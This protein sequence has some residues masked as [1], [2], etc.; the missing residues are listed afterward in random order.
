MLSMSTTDWVDKVPFM[1]DRI[2]FKTIVRKLPF[3]STPFISQDGCSW[4]DVF[5]D[6]V[7]KGFP[8]AVPDEPQNGSSGGPIYLQ[9]AED[10]LAF[11]S[12]SV[13]TSATMVLQSKQ[14]K[15]Q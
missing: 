1:A 3:V 4:S 13:A 6:L 11:P 15:E 5:F 12:P 14:K 9:H 8:C 10:P 7:D 2:L